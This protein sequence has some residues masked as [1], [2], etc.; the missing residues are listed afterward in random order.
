MSSELLET[1]VGFLE[2]IVDDLERQLKVLEKENA[3]LLKRALNA[4]FRIQDHYET[5]NN[6]DEVDRRLW[7]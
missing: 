5:K 2:R 3:T 4:E 7:G 1:R 6:P